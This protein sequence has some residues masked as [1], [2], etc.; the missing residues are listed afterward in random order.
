M[1]HQRQLLE[2]IPIFGALS[3]ATR[4]FLLQRATTESRQAGAFFFREKEPAQSVYVL[5]SGRVAV[6]KQLND[7]EF[8]LRHLQPGA[9]FGEMAI[10]D[11]FPRSASVKAIEDSRAFKIGAAALMDL[12]THD[13][14]QFTLLQMNFGREVCRRLRD[15][16]ERNFQLK[17][18]TNITDWDWVFRQ[19]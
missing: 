13:L 9:C 5:E 17:T 15:A 8:V 16:D 19:F 3:A 12:Y 11:M 6:T 10:M 18:Q 14:E 1:Q 4:D 2:N 7:E